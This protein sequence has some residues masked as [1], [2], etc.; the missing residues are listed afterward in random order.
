MFAVSGIL[1]RGTTAKAEVFDVEIFGS[2]ITIEVP[3]AAPEGS[4]VSADPPSSPD[5]LPPVIFSAP[6]PAGSGARALGLAG[7]FTAVADDATAASWNPAGLM[8]LEW[9]EAS[10]L[11]RFSHEKQRHHSSDSTMTLGD[12]EFSNLALNYLSLVYPFEIAD[13]RCV[14]SMNYQEAYD[15]EQRFTARFDQASSS[16]NASGADRVY[17]DTTVQ[18]I[19]DGN[20]EMDLITSA[21]THQHSAISQIINSDLLTDVDFDQEGIID[22]ITPALAIRILP[23]LYA[24]IS[25]NFYQDSILGSKIRSKTRASYTG[26]ASSIADITDTRTTHSSYSYTGTYQPPPI[27]PG[28]EPDPIPIEGGG[29]LEPF[30]DE[31]QTRKSETIMVDGEYV[32]DNSF[33]DLFGV[34]A[35]IG[36]LAVVSKLLT[37]GFTIDTPWTAEANQTKRTANTMTTYNEDR[38]TAL[39]T[40]TAETVETRGVEFTFP[41]YCA[42]G[43]LLRWSNRFYTSIDASW[44]QWSEFSFRAKGSEKV[45]PLDGSPMGENRVDDTW[46][47]AIGVEYFLVFQHTETPLRA[48]ISWE[49]RPAIGSPDDFLHLS[50]GS[51][52]SL[53]RGESR[54]ILDLAYQISYGNDVHGA[55]A[56]GH[57]GVSSDITEHQVFLSAIKHF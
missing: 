42:A 47:V 34:N 23:G 55:R 1:F 16:R 4:L 13:H 37:V 10:I 6:L 41:L 50:L 25:V 27:V 46:R 31:E 45:N 12:D 11:F 5:F 33:D 36:I 48:G 51:G 32:E 29:T 30:T 56:P 28:Y 49:E 3:H 22:A 17:T 40:S 15:F 21:T 24:G 43:A 20:L 14:F 35:T 54:I 18:H 39:E 44:T 7:A 52:I 9:P 53:G 38:S 19:V 8:Q 57:E 26:T 2:T